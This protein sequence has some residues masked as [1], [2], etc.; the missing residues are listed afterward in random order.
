MSQELLIILNFIFYSLVNNM[1]LFKETVLLLS[2]ISIL[3][4]AQDKDEEK[5]IDDFET[6]SSRTCRKD[7][8]NNYGNFCA[9]LD[10]KRGTCCDWTK[11]ECGNHGGWCANVIK[12][13]F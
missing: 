8:I 13:R 4:S 11:S 12:E 3:V 9:T 5:N 10:M 1:K 7:C 6:V 2:I